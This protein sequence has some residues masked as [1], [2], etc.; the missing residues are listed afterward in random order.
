MLI[1]PLKTIL[2]PFLNVLLVKRALGADQEIF[3]G[4]SNSNYFAPYVTSSTK[5]PFPCFVKI[6]F[7]TEISCYT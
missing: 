6:V 3:I 1:P 4:H 2:D 7:E 5:N